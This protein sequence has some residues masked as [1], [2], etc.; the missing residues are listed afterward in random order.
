MPEARAVHGE[1]H[2]DEIRPVTALFADI[3]GSTGLGE[4]LAPD[5]V[6]A[7]VGECVTRMS[8]VVEQHGGVVQ[9]YM[10]DGICAYFGVPAA[11][12]DDAERAAWAALGIVDAVA[13][14][15]VEVEQAWGI[16]DLDVRV[17]INSGPTAVG[18]VGAADPATVALGDTTN[19]AARLQSA[20]EPGTVVVGG[21]TA[22]TLEGR[23][24]LAPL[25]EV[26]VKGRAE[27]VH[28]YRLGGPIATHPVEPET[29][30]VGRD[31][32]IAQL[33]RAIED[34]EAGRGSVLLIVGDIGMGKTR[35]LA[36]LRRMATDGVEWLEG[37]TPSY[38]GRVAYGPFAAALRRW[39][40]VSETDPDIVVRTRLRARVGPLFDEDAALLSY[41]GVVLGLAPDAG[42]ERELRSGP[43]EAVGEQVRAVFLAW[44]ETLA[45]QRPVVLALDDAHW[46]DATTGMLADTVLGLT[47][48]APFLLALTLRPERGSEGWR[49][50]LRALDEFAHR[51]AEVT[52]PP[53]EPAAIEVLIERDL[54]PGKL[55][56]KLRSQV[57][58]RAEGNP[59]FAEELAHMAA[60][61]GTARTQTWAMSANAPEDLPPALEG[62]LVARIDRLPASARRLAQVAAVVGRDFSVDLVERVLDTDD[63]DE[64]LGLLLRAGIVREQ[65]RFP[66]FVCTFRHVLLQEAA[67][68]TLTPTARRELYGVVADAAEELADDRPEL[69]AFYRYR[70]ETPERAL[71]YLEEA[72]R[73]CVDPRR[74]AEL[75]DR[76]R[77]LAERIGDRAAVDRIQAGGGGIASGGA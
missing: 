66:G 52:L 36:E 67:L 54:P 51:A 8:R 7:L 71:P 37:S 55:G 50:R 12:E 64:D 26:T 27:P 57:V 62:L 5:E 43:A 19:V 4:R 17:G 15:A 40:G 75:W 73:R 70:S 28:P 18:T 41:L 9:A 14:Y 65:R 48:R 39:V 10:G 72:A 58:E 61:L 21:M 16:A 3:V 29:P 74:A 59:F 69:L 25:G 34:V 42:V 63:L 45:G 53:L 2:P 31:L 24:A 35:M 13:R 47:D 11:H 33:R 38:G 76:A 23:F 6:K 56:E 60:E 44:L 20:A 1:D 49:V 68:D 22:L 32:E 30:L 77:R 46:M